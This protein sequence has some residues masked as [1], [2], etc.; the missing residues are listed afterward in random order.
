MSGPEVV[1]LCGGP[2]DER[3]VSLVSGRAVADALEG[4]RACRRIELAESRLPADLDPAAVVIFPAL[5]GAFGEDGGV[6][7][8][9][10]AGDFAY[11]GSDATS[12][13]LCIHKS[14]TKARVSAHGVKVLPGLCFAAAALPEASKVIDALGGDL[15]L[16]PVDHGSSH[17]LRFIESE[18]RL[19]E[20]LA[21][22]EKIDGEWLLEPRVRGRELSV[23]LLGG[24]AMGV[25]EIEP[26]S[27]A[28]DYHSK[29]TRGATRYHCPADLSE[30][31]TQ[32][33]QIAAETAFAAC[34][35]RDFGRVDFMLSADGNPYFLEI[36]TLPGLTPTSLLPR[37][38]AQFGFDFPS[39]VEAMLQP[40]LE[41][42]SRK[43]VADH[44]R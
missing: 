14:E 32:E 34:E 26:Q 3:E 28:Y 11:A 36:N 12:S 9:L 17:G 33:V 4:R 6:Q 44:V 22:F 25:V 15:V 39:L 7:S 16:K 38:A 42:F 10:E 19:A 35:C 23:G 2:S 41:R 43:E 37:S 31:L 8:L 18:A 27:G 13:K 20:A 24:K 5:H 29:Y 40:C 1:I 21:E 30:A